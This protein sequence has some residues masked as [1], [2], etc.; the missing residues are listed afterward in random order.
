MAH[1]K[2][3]RGPA[4]KFVLED[5]SRVLDVVALITIAA[6]PGLI[7]LMVLP[8]PLVLPVLSILS[9]L[10]ACGIA[11]YAQRSETNR[12]RANT[13]HW[14]LAW[15]FAVIW[16]VAGMLGNPRTLIEW[17]DRLALS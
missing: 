11:F 4:Q 10:I 12:R 17:L 16:V 14:E 5:P 15:A 13:A 6:A 1:W 3:E 2:I 9:F 8:L 7:L